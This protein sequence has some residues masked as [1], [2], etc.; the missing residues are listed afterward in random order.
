MI[1][2][3]AEFSLHPEQCE[4]RRGG[5]PVPLE[6][7]VFNLLVY[8]VENRG[9][10]VSKDDLIATV[11]GGR[12]VSDATLSSRIS[13][14]RHALDDSGEAQRVIR[15]MP[16]LGFRFVAE[17]AVEDDGAPEPA[18]EEAA[19]D[20]PDQTVR[21]CRA[22]DG[23]SIAYATSGKGPPLVKAA[24]WLS[25][26]EFDWESPV[27]RPLM[28]A[29]TRDFFFVRYDERGNGLSDWAV[30]DFSL[31][32]FVADLEAVVEAAG[33]DRFALYGES[34]GCP[35]SIAYAVRHPERVSRLVLYGGFAQGA[36]SR[37]SRIDVAR[38]EAITTLVRE[39]WGQDNPAFRQIFTS[40]LMPDA[41]AEQMGWFNDL[42]RKTTSP[43]N[44]ARLRIA[45]DEIDVTELLSQVRVP[46][47]VL[48]RRGDSRQPFEEGRRLGAMIPDAQFVALEGRNH[49]ILEHEPEWPR[50]LCEVRQFVLD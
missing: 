8:L 33:I 22:A 38:E 25:H 41:T 49:I 12:I 32:A 34:H 15:T 24:N 4:L 31:D 30:A 19:P 37:G 2:H 17:V 10:V 27:W 50:F 3:F 26:L 43:E 20:L 45:I 16:R 44:A 18:V 5:A 7:Q 29:F 23:V 39:G 21:F 35:V 6:P 1:Y 36:R 13:A 46:T 42:Q 47:L 40:Q 9:R 11:W 28:S 14:A 48:H